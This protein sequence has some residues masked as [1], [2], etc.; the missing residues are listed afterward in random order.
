VCFGFCFCFLQFPRAPNVF[1]QISMGTFI[2]FV[3][4]S[5]LFVFWCFFSVGHIFFQPSATL[6]HTE[7]TKLIELIWSQKDTL[8]LADLQR[9]AEYKS[10]LDAFGEWH[11]LVAEAAK[12]MLADVR[13]YASHIYNVHNG[14]I[15]YKNQDR[16]DTSMRYGVDARTCF[17]TI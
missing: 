6:P 4:N 16:L 13:T 1:E 15:A 17:E 9:T 3:R 12:D 10:C 5:D 7:V 8:R 11:P 14:W 2:R